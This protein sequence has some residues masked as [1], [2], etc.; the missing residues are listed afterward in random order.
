VHSAPFLFAETPAYL[1]YPGISGAEEPF[2]A[3]LRGGMQKPS[4]GMLRINMGFRRRGRNP[5]RGFDF[6]VI[7]LDK[8]Q[9]NGLKGLGSQDQVPADE[10]LS[11]MLHGIDSKNSFRDWK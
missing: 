11:V 4:I 6:K 2:H 10:M 1:K 9:T 3:E 8:K 5:D 7:V